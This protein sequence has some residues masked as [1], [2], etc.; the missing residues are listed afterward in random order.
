MELPSLT[1][2]VILKRYKRFFADI[3]LPSGEVV[4]AHVPNTGS[5]KTCWSPGWKALI[6]PATN[7]ERK[8]KW[9]LELLSPGKDFIMVNT[10]NANKLAQEALEEKRLAPFADYPIVT[11]EQKILDSRF[12]F[13]LTGLKGQPDCWVEVKNVTLLENPPQASFPDAVSTRG[14]KHLRDLITLKQQG[15]RAAMLYVVS[16]SD[17]E[18][19]TSA[20][21]ID[22]D[23]AQALKEAYRAGVEIYAF[24]VEKNGQHLILKTPLP[25][26]GLS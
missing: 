24:K 15:H 16:R 18:S 23:Y 11:A 14:Q 17:A 26:E 4:V 2:G 5:M 9:T 12:D 20:G 21:H 10:A 6:S 19:F 7:P 8:L 13:H 1:E 25:I 3:Q 22:P